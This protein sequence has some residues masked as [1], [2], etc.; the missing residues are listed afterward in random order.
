MA[1]LTN[2]QRRELIQQALQV[3]QSAYAPYSRYQVGAALLCQDGRIFVGAN[4][5]NAAYPSSMCAERVA[6][7]TAVTAGERQFAAVVVATANGGTPCGGCRQVLAEFGLETIVILVDETG[8]VVSETALAD[9]L[10]GAFLSGD[11]K[12]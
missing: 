1:P 7:F 4:V 5:E 2:A 3:R 6:V 8:R 11:L 10:P 12:K 9:L